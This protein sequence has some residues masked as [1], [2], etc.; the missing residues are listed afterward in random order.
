LWRAYGILA[1]ARVLSSHEVMNLLSAVRLGVAMG[2]PMGLDLAQVNELMLLAQPAHI[3]RLFGKEMQPEERD[4]ARAELVRKRMTR[5]RPR[6]RSS[7]GSSGNA[8]N[9]GN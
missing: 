7:G 6:R 5:K 3:Q 8:G 4:V 2:E 1:N 9:T